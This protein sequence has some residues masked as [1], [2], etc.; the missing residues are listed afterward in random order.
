MGQL[1][2]V[3]RKSV[4]EDSPIVLVVWCPDHHLLTGLTETSHGGAKPR[5]THLCRRGEEGVSPDRISRAHSHED[6]RPAEVV[7]VTVPEVRGPDYQVI[8][9]VPCQI[10]GHS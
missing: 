4:Q 7:V 6:I 2:L 10:T 3:V 8:S 1:E 5:P 9:P